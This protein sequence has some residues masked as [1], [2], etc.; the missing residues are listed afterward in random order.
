VIPADLTATGISFYDLARAQ[1]LS[2]H[3][4]RHGAVHYMRGQGGVWDFID[5]YEALADALATRAARHH[6]P[7]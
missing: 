3:A 1:G 6:E 4:A 7:A 5:Y 2:D